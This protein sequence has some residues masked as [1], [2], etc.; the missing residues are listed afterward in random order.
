[1]EKKKPKAKQPKVKG[2]FE[3]IIGAAMTGNPKPDKKKEKL[4][5]KAAG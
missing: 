2:S 1:M 5:N 3:E 4:K